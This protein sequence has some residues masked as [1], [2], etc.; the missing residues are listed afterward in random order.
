MIQLKLNSKPTLDGATLLAEAQACCPIL[1]LALCSVEDVAR[2]RVGVDNAWIVCDRQSAIER[3]SAA[4]PFVAKLNPKSSCFDRFAS[5]FQNMLK[6]KPREFLI[7]DFENDGYAERRRLRVAV[8][9]LENQV[10][11]A[12]FHIPSRTFRNPFSDAGE[13]ITSPARDFSS[14]AELLNGYCGYE[15]EYGEEERYL[16]IGYQ[17]GE[18]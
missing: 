15:C 12:T 14:T 16:F 8:H 9:A 4:I 17:P 1:W 2:M 10:L 7:L 3:L 18:F 5:E 11:D 13:D 6:S